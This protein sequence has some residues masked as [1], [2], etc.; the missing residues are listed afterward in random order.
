MKPISRRA[1][2]IPHSATLKIL[3]ITNQMR[4]QGHDIISLSVGE[5]D[6]KT[7][8]PII[9]AAKD[10]LDKGETHYA[11]SRGLVELRE[12][13]A[14]KMREENK[15]PA[16]KD[17]I[18]VTIAK[19]G[20]FMVSEAILQHGDEVI[21]PDPGWVSYIPISIFSGAH[22]IPLPAYEYDGFEPSIEHL[23]EIVSEKTKLL[24]LNTPSNPTGA[25]YHMKTLKA[26]ADLAED[27][28]F[29]VMSDEIYE[30]LI[31]GRKHIS[32]ASIG[33]MWERTITLNGFS[34]AYAMTGWR[35]GW[36]AAPKE[37]IDVLD[38]IQ[39]QTITCNPPFIQRAAIVALRE[40]A[41]YVEEM[42]KEFNHRRMA[43]IDRIGEMMVLDAFKPQGA[44]YI[45]A[46]YHADMNSFEVVEHL[47]REYGVAVTPGGSFGVHGEGYIRISYANSM[48]NILEGLNRIEKGLSALE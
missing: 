12:E 11:P 2:R 19:H 18:L 42:R 37:I 41:P 14:R 3:E 5:P 9:E 45:F 35:L 22:Y 8:Q 32:I 40:C 27:Y 38:K 47:I 16:D 43:A 15:V 1:R 26:I 25:V 20:I 30:K 10:A 44:F 4:R 21:V 34:K 24:V 48:E 33:N 36:I 46:K 29:Y 39:Q 31:Y 6:F 13:I 23:Q 17:N 28:D 7:P